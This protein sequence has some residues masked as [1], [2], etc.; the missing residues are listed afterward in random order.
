KNHKM[1]KLYKYCAMI[2]AFMIILVTPI[3]AQ[4]LAVMPPKLN[5][6]DI[7]LN[8]LELVSTGLFAL[9]TMIFGGK[10]VIVKKK[11]TQLLELLNE[12]QRALKDGKIDKTEL[13]EI[14]KD[15]KALLGKVDKK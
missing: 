9:L 10:I 3:F 1:K 8:N 15:M 13:E 12:I 5:I 7:I 2:I 11:F 4:E 14:V 6:W